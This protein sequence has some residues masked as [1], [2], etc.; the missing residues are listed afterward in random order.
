[1]RRGD[2]AQVNETT[3]ISPELWQR[4]KRAERGLDHGNGPITAEVRLDRDARVESMGL[5]ELGAYKRKGKGPLLLNAAPAGLVN[6]AAIPQVKTIGLAAN[7]PKA[8]VT[9]LGRIA[10]LVFVLG[11]GLVLIGP[12]GQKVTPPQPV[13]DVQQLYEQGRQAYD[14][15]RQAQAA[16]L[17]RQALDQKPAIRGLRLNLAWLYYEMGRTEDALAQ[18]R[19]LLEQNPGDKEAM[20]ALDVIKAKTAPNAES[21]R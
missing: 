1:M 10:G 5:D 3:I 11:L 16:E 8:R 21:D 2:S 9:A 4:I 17:W 20:S 15:G 12:F 19:V 18:V 7:D 14:Q 13:K 6:L